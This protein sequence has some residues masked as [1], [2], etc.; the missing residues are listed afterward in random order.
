MIHYLG[1]VALVILEFG[2]PLQLEKCVIPGKEHLVAL[3]L[4]FWGLNAHKSHV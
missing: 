1:I 4:V 2:Q 3:V